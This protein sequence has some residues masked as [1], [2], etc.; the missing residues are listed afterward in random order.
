M[1][2]NGNKS[3]ANISISTPGFA[4]NILLGGETEPSCTESNNLLRRECVLQHSPVFTHTP[5][6]LSLSLLGFAR[7]LPH[8]LV[9]DVFSFHLTILQKL[10]KL[11]PSRTLPFPSEVRG[12]FSVR[13][14]HI[15]KGWCLGNWLVCRGKFTQAAAEDKEDLCCWE[16]R[17]CSLEEGLLWAVRYKYFAKKCVFME[18]W[19][20]A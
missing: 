15:H 8:H 12:V 14:F 4:G 5:A 11:V 6:L 1:N 9:T 20:S 18:T 16:R 3:I 10:Q 7:C 19:C 13:V 17:C 2:Y